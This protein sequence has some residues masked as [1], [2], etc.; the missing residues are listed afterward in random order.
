MCERGDLEFCYNAVG[1]S[2][3]LL[4]FLTFGAVVSED[5]RETEVTFFIHV[6]KYSFISIGATVNK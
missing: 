1:G 5:F 2:L 6:E 3:R 4:G